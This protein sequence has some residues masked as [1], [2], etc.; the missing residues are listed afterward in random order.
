VIN[1]PTNPHMLAK[2]ILSTGRLMTKSETP[3]FSNP[4]P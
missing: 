4:G 3:T 2:Q 1:E